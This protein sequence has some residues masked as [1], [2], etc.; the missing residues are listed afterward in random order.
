MHGLQH[1]LRAQKTSIKFMRKV[2]LNKDHL[3]KIIDEAETVVNYCFRGEI[4]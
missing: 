2:F 1:G 3:N 4:K